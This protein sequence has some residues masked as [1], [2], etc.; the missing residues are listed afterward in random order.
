MVVVKRFFTSFLFAPSP[1]LQQN[2]CSTTDRQLPFN[3]SLGNTA[4]EEHGIGG[5]ASVYARRVRPLATMHSRAGP[6]HSSTLMSIAAKSCLSQRVNQRRRANNNH[7]LRLY[8]EAV[9]WGAKS[10]CISVRRL[11]RLSSRGITSLSISR[12]GDGRRSI[13]FEQCI[14]TSP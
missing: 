2:L 3:K 12:T 13:S 7:R 6:P 14:L 10:A 4:T 8:T 5:G 1:L 11:L 9:R